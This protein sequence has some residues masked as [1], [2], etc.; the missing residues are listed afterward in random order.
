MGLGTTLM[1][2]SDFLGILSKTQNLLPFFV[3]CP[4][5]ALC[6]RVP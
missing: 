1:V 5:H 6:V 2:Q 3:D 4:D